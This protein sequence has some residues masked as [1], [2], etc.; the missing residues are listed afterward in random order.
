MN[1]KQQAV[2]LCAILALSGCQTE[3]PPAEE[4][5]GQVPMC[6]SQPTTT[7]E[8]E[9]SFGSR[10]LSDENVHVKYTDAAV[11]EFSIEKNAD[12]RDV[13]AFAITAYRSVLQEKLRKGEA[14]S[15]GEIDLL[16]YICYVQHITFSS[17]TAY[18]Y[19]T[20]VNPVRAE[21]G[22]P[23]DFA[24]GSKDVD[25][26]K[27]ANPLANAVANFYT[28]DNVLARLI[29]RW[30][31]DASTPDANSIFQE[32][33]SPTYGKK[34]KTSFAVVRPEDFFAVVAALEGPIAGVAVAMYVS[35]Y[36]DKELQTR[37]GAYDGHE[38]DVMFE[39]YNRATLNNKQ[40]AM[41][42][43]KVADSLKFYSQDLGELHRDMAASIKNTK[44]SY[45]KRRIEDLR[46]EFS[47][48][49]E[50]DFYKFREVFYAYP[51]ICACN[52]LLGHVKDARHIFWLNDKEA[53]TD[54]TMMF[55][56]TTSV[57]DNEMIK[58]LNSRYAAKV[59]ADTLKELKK[60][61]GDR[62][63]KEIQAKCALWKLDETEF[64]LGDETF[65]QR[66][67]KYL[68]RENSGN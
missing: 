48:W 46:I 17:F 45:T 67:V 66:K 28:N 31:Q 56:E 50:D 21:R 57:K 16:R 47:G 7:V 61:A 4:G 20:L 23:G 30:A 34:M 55:C 54:A 12:I 60:R 14:L 52:T 65:G 38:Y 49:C 62:T 5:T 59:Y 19:S 35:K 25:P 1:I 37:D 43:G 26:S 53:M 24:A 63:Y 68:P 51:F 2:A 39:E 18:G 3:T 32:I 44:D 40:K 36:H 42:W 13:Q 8:V 27:D 22:V 29:D 6:V 58:N 10:T 64:V 33:V 15:K 11:R 9:S 41:L